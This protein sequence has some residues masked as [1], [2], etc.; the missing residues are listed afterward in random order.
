MHHAAESLCSHLPQA[1]HLEELSKPVFNHSARVKKA[2]QP[3]DTAS[4]HRESKLNPH[5]SKAS[6]LDLQL[7][8]PIMLESD[9][10]EK[11]VLMAQSHCF[12]SKIQKSMKNRI[13]LIWEQEVTELSAVEVGEEK[14]QKPAMNP[15]RFL[16][17][18]RDMR[19]KAAEPLEQRV[20]EAPPR[21]KL[22]QGLECNQ[23]QLLRFIWCVLR[24]KKALVQ[25]D[26]TT[27]NHRERAS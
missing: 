21:G 16:L 3:D 4:N 2:W 14:E 17:T 6:M 1:A 7:S 5:S 19:R 8:I 18:R 25:P 13:T 22:K 23:R 12:R 9:L 20:V 27:D 15:F 10:V 26:D 11:V 24:V